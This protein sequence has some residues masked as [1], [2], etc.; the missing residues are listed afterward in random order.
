MK[1]EL[2]KLLSPELSVAGFCEAVKNLHPEEIFEAVLL[3]M[4]EVNRIYAAV[5]KHEKMDLERK[6]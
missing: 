4:M 1:D 6:P 3:E 2:T 5:N